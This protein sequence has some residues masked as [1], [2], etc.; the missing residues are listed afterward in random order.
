MKPHP[1]EPASGRLARI[2]VPIDFSPMA[3]WALES[4]LSLLEEQPEATI[5]LLHVVEPWSMQLH[6][7]GEVPQPL[8]I[9]A[10]IAQAEQQ[11]AQ[12]RGVYESRV[13]VETRV[14]VGTAAQVICDVAEKESIGV[15]VLC[16]HGHGAE[17]RATIGSV[18]ERVV[19][20]S[21]CP[22]LVVKP[23]RDAAREFVQLRVAHGLKE[24]IVGYDHR[25][26]A[27]LALEAA[28]A[29]TDG[30]SSRI[31]LVHALEPPPPLLGE[32]VR[33]V[34]ASL[35]EKAKAWLHRVVEGHAS[36]GI[37]WRVVVE[38]GHPWKLLV[39]TAQETGCDLIVA[40]PH[41]QSGWRHC[42]IGSTAQRVV[43]LAPCSVLAVK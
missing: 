18:A 9:T 37:E 39:D 27:K 5:I 10:R 13:A 6:S 42:F 4:I 17:P 12:L 8:S 15:V 11:L 33:P 24:V 16:S 29:M 22:V 41:D 38:A 21:R 2:L 1:L 23:P 31:T 43:R 19:Q 28:L 34:D 14:L 7:G 35:I 26:G 3:Q 36:A 20:D 32:L 40:G 25:D 30:R